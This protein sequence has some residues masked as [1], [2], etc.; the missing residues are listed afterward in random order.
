MYSI[1]SYG[2]ML[3]DTPRMEAYTAALCAT[4][5]PGSVVLDLGCGPGV[6]ALLACK[7]GARRVY[8]IEPDGVIELARETALA[9]GVAERIEFY[10][11]FSTD[12]TLPERA[13]II[14]SDL[15]GMLPWFRQHIPSIIDARNR[16]L[17]TGGTLIPQRDVLWAAVVEV[18]DRYGEIIGPWERGDLNLSAAKGVATSTFRKARISPEQLLVAPACCTKLDYNQIQSPDLRAEISWQ[19]ERS[20]TAHGFSLWFDSELIDDIGFSN[21]PSAPELIYGN[22]LFLFPHPVEIA[23]GDRIDLRLSADFISDDYVW[24]WDTTFLSTGDL[25]TKASFTQSTF[26]GVPL[27]AAQLRKQAATYKPT[28]DQKGQIKSFILNSMTGDNSLEEIATRLVECFPKHYSDWKAALN[29]VTAVSL[30]VGQ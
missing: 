2:Q 5:K 20:G 26:F 19:A 16:L 14:V 6:F 23:Q 28:L 1:Y 24:R 17:A 30:E 9:N 7:L 29:D 3:A 18:P 25:Q 8:A 21:N 27:S 15:R 4:V 13:D 12:I 11:D 22:A 10:Q